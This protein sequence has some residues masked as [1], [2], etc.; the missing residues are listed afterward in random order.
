MFPFTFHLEPKSFSLLLLGA[1][2]CL[3]PLLTH[4]PSLLIL[5]HQLQFTREQREGL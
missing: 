4:T 2:V 1:C 5:E 3:L